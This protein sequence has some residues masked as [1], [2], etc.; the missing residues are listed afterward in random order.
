MLP[1]SDY[2]LPSFSDEL[3]NA[4]HK[5]SHAL[6]ILRRF[7]E[8]AGEF[9]PDGLFLSKAL[10][11][12]LN[13][14]EIRQSRVLNRHTSPDGTVKLLIGFADGAAVEAVLM[15]WYHTGRAAGCVSSQVGCAMGCDFCASTKSGLRRS[16][17]A[18]EIV[19]QYLW[20]RGEAQQQGRRLTSLVF[21]GMG[22]PMQ[23]LDNVIQ[24]IQR[25]GE[26]ST[27]GLGRRHIT[28]STV[29]IVPGIERLA[30]SGLGVHL[31]VSLHAPDDATRTRLVP[32]NRRFKVADILDAAR[33]YQDVTGQIVTIEYCMLAD[34]NDSNEQA[35]ELARLLNGFRAHVNLIPYNWIG[36]GLSG[37]IYRRPS[38]ERLERFLSILRDARVVAHFRKT[39]GDDV[40]AACGQLAVL[41]STS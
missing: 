34:V 19:E 21:M 40:A 23:N 4:G 18:G 29:G 8:T 12:D 24:S 1:L 39:R 32:M 41:N 35:H 13:G 15:P 22:E 2:D 20:L 17:T 27:A 31:A 33:D 7:Y 5:P 3:R 14:S 25:L 9:T 38:Q 16:L 10:L 28:V 30:A 37:A 6:L 36:S 26:Q 11:A